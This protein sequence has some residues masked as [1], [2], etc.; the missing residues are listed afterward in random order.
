M[1]F[2]LHIRKYLHIRVMNNYTADPILRSQISYQVFSWR[3][4]PQIDIAALT[5]RRIR[6]IF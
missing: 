4:Y 2:R 1:D 5:K 6:V 3:I